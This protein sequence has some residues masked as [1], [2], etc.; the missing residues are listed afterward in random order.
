MF[1][2]FDSGMLLGCY[3]VVVVEV[4]PY[5]NMVI[6]ENPC[7]YVVFFGMAEW[8]GYLETILLFLLS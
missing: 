4:L 1:I 5:E 3:L 6:A 8:V 2:L 7:F